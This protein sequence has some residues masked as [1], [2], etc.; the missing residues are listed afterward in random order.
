MTPTTTTQF[1]SPCVEEPVPTAAIRDAELASRPP[2]DSCLRGWNRIIDDQLIQWGATGVEVPEDDFVEPSHEVIHFAC[3]IA[4]RMRDGGLAPPLRVVPDG[5][6]GISFERREQ[7]RF[8]SL[9][10]HS[11]MSIEWIVCDGTQA[12]RLPVAYNSFLI[13]GLQKG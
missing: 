7:A 11:D 8:F 12:S 13:Q 10:V 9:N 6:G 1:L 3:S 2:S 4:Q 5:E